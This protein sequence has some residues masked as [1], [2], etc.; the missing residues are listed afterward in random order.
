[1][2][3]TD[4]TFAGRNISYQ[5]FEDGYDIYLDGEP[6]ISQREPYGKMYDKTKSYEENCLLQIEEIT[7][8]TK[9]P[10]PQEQLYTLDQAA[11][12]IASEVA[13]DE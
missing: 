10:E 7:K 1:M 8:E 2:T 4:K 9:E 13:S 11:A 5:I 6:W 12:I 3:S